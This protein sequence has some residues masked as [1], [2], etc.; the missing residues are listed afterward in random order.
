MSSDHQPPYSIIVPDATLKRAEAYA[1]QLQAGKVNAGAYLDRQ[2]P[3]TG[4]QDI[5]GLDLLGLLFDTRQPQIFAE[6]AVM[7][8]GSDWSRVELGLLGDVSVAVP[9]TIYDDGNHHSPTAHDPSFEGV[10]VF[11]AGALL[12]N[13]HGG[14]PADWG[15]VTT[16]DGELSEEGYYALYARRL[17]PVFAYIDQHARAPRSALITIPGLGCGQ[18]AGPFRGQL[19][20]RLKDVLVRL[21]SEYGPRFNNIKAVYYDPYSNCQNERSIIEGIEFMVR[22]LTAP[23][24]QAKSQLCPPPA[25]AET[26]DDFSECD[27]YSLVAWDH[28]SWPGNDFYAG[29]RS[30]DDGVKAAATS[31]IAVLTGIDGE[32][33]R[34]RGCYIPPDHFANWRA[35]VEEGSRAGTLRLWSRSAVWLNQGV[36]TKAEC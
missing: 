4:W 1:Q 30:T 35:V 36:L 9:V 21:L 5:D 27:L 28:V 26:G 15:E 18:F 10:L 8:D 14:I 33:V 31:A 2:R 20:Q 29:A 24:N 25:Y 7:G 19:E 3:D 13:D 12:R 32:Y 34:S 16:A 17:L 6:S 22:P 11:T 23:G